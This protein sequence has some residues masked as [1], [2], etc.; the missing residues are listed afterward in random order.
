M[1]GM[2]MG[3]LIVILIVA[4]LVLG[5]TKLPD[6]A[7][8]IGKG[9]RELRKHTT[10]L[11]Q[12]LD[13]DETI[14]GSIRELKGA[15]RGDEPA[16]SIRPNHPAARKPVPLPQEIPPPVAAPAL[17]EAGAPGEAV[18][19]TNPFAPVAVSEKNEKV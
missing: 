15:L 8:A 11:Q 10:D 12:T 5:P 4:L 13:N 17:P 9:I 14:G 6:A 3:E 16:P 19:A 7:K 1:F 2:G 18:A